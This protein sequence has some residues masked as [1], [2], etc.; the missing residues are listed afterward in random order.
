MG[1]SATVNGANDR[2][3]FAG[4]DLLLGARI[5]ENW[6]ARLADTA[7]DIAQRDRVPTPAWHRANSSHALAASYWPHSL[8]RVRESLA[9]IASR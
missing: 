7:L 4:E 9:A 2:V 1:E 3:N 5:V 8:D 6:T